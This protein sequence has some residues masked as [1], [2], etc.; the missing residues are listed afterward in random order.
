MNIV[1]LLKEK[2]IENI[3]LAVHR[4]IRLGYVSEIGL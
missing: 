4:E 3:N 2:H 1:L